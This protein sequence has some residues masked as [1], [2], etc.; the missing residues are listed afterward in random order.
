MEPELLTKAK[1]YAVEH[2]ILH[3]NDSQLVR[4][5]LLKGITDLSDMELTI[6][7]MRS[8]L[9]KQKKETE[10][11]LKQMEHISTVNGGLVKENEILKTNLKKKTKNKKV[12]K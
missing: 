1:T 12:K 6:Y 5:I 2:K 3:K 11:L 9:D 10:N 7:L 8:Q 4:N